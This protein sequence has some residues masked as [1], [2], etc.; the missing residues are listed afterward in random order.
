MFPTRQPGKSAGSGIFTVTHYLAM[1]KEWS[2]ADFQARVE[3][4]IAQLGEPETTLL[5]RAGL[6]GD[7]IRKAPKRGRRIDTVIRIARALRWT[8][9][10][11]LGLQDP[12]LFLDRELEIDPKKLGLALA[13]AEDVIGENPE[14]RS[15]A[16]LADVASLV[17]SV[18]SERESGGLSI[19]S[20]V[21]RSVIESILRRGFPI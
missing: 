21:M 18:L 19:D 9:G 16:T 10:Q 11:A 2:E 13:I 7:E 12:T 8:V 20:D 5:R 1:T 15:A 6:T 17:Y 4:R 14:G 3:A